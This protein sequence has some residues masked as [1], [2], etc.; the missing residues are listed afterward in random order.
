MRGSMFVKSHVEGQSSVWAASDAQ[1][2]RAIIMFHQGERR[3]GDPTSRALA[4]LS[5]STKTYN[6]G[7]HGTF[8]VNNSQTPTHCPAILSLKTVIWPLPRPSMTN[9]A[10]F[11]EGKL[12]VARQNPPL[13]TDEIESIPICHCCPGLLSHGNSPTS[14]PCQVK[15]FNTERTNHFVVGIQTVSSRLI[16]ECLVEGEGPQLTRIG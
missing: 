6:Q 16:D 7:F 10:G 1:C 5:Q 3:T 12:A 15:T 8:C 2:G 13:C 11:P 4:L 9:A 14:G